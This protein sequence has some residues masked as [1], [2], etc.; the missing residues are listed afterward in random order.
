MSEDN[1]DKKSGRRK[2]IKV[3]GFIGLALGL[4]YYSWGV[5]AFYAFKGGPNDYYWVINIAQGF[6]TAENEYHGFPID[7][8][9]DN[10]L[11]CKSQ[12]AKNGIGTLGYCVAL[13]N[14]GYFGEC[15]WW[16][17]EDCMVLEG[18]AYLLGRPDF[19]GKAIA[20]IYDPCRYTPTV[21]EIRKVV[22]PN[23]TS[24]RQQMMGWRYFFVK[25][26]DEQGEAVFNTEIQLK[27]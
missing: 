22:P 12:S 25:L 8:T 18:E 4:L 2:I 5:Y 16:R 24:F 9:E 1:S 17:F 26:F 20:A 6:A 14:R 10:P 15:S 7:V 23:N 3:L 13:F 19:L 11:T 21:E 27:K